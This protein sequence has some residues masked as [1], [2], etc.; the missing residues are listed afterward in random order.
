MPV[1]KSHYLNHLIQ[2]LYASIKLYWRNKKLRNCTAHFPQNLPTSV[3]KSF[4]PSQTVSLYIL[5]T[6]LMLCSIILPKHLW[7]KESKCFLLAL[8]NARF[9]IYATNKEFYEHYTVSL[10]GISKVIRFTMWMAALNS[11]KPFN[12]ITKQCIQH[13]FYTK[14]SCIHKKVN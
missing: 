6:Y 13:T 8:P 9:R 1:L 10:H 12:H 4:I 2:M 5:I 7:S 14:H 3:D 11:S